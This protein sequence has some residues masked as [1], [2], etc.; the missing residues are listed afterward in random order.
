MRMK[1][2]PNAAKQIVKTFLMY[3]NIR[4]SE[5]SSAQ[6][7]MSRSK[8]DFFPSVMLLGPLPLV[9]L[10]PDLLARGLEDSEVMA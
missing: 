1:S 2:K 10:F 9:S 3:F 5:D 4:T 7:L 8:P 6:K